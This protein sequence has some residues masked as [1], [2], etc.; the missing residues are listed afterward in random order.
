MP[1]LQNINQPW[2]LDGKL[3]IKFS[4]IKIKR[5]PIDITQQYCT[6][7]VC[8]YKLQKKKE[9]H[10]IVQIKWQNEQTMAKI[11]QCITIWFKFIESS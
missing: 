4:Q 7:A 11:S 1:Q 2:K 3:Y 10:E 9:L 6:T 8:N 5:R